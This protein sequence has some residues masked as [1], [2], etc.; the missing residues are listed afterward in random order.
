MHNALFNSNIIK[1]T[2]DK[3]VNCNVYCNNQT[4]PKQYEIVIC[5]EFLNLTND[6]M[7]IIDSIFKIA[8][9]F[10]YYTI[11]NLSNVKVINN[12]HGLFKN[13]QYVNKILFNSYGV[14]LVTNANPIR[15]DT[16]EMFLVDL[17]SN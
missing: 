3:Y 9:R 6:D 16:N 15:C 7:H 17:L 10:N 4:E 14:D 13:L 11:L 8:E 1:L 2:Y 5:S 12:A